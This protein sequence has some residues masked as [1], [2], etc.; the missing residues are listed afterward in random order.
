M[1]PLDFPND[2]GISFLTAVASAKLR[3]GHADGQVEERTV[4]PGSY[5]VGREDADIVLPH[6]SVSARHAVLEVSALELHAGRG[7]A[8]CLRYAA[9]CW[10]RGTMKSALSVSCF[11]L[12]AR[13]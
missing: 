7:R 1:G 4:A 13:A 9:S 2:S 8:S 6:G 10:R 3:I 12:L 5:R 11:A